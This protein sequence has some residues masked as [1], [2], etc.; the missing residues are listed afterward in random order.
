MP[1]KTDRQRK[2]YCAGQGASAKSD[3]NPSFVEKIKGIK[4]KLRL[5]RERLG[6]ERIEKE[7]VLLRHEQEQ[8][9]RLKKEAQVESQ[10]EAITQQRMKAQQEMKAVQKARFERKVAPIRKGI[11]RAVSGYKTVVEAERKVEK[12]LKKK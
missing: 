2:A 9:E 6:R 7:K 8:A 10:R 3:V 4:E 11:Q 1:F 12:A 5:R